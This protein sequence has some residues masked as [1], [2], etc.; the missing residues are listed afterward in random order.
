MKTRRGHVWHFAQCLTYSRCSVHRLMTIT[1]VETS[2]PGS[3]SWD[4][5]LF[6]VFFFLSFS[7][8]LLGL[9]VEKMEDSEP[10]ISK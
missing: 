8:V 7:S 5:V 4:I 1:V 6:L 2:N 3:Q 10:R 9:D